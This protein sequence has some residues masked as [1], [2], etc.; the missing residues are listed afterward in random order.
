MKIYN[1]PSKTAEKKVASIV[2]RGLG[3][4]KKDVLA[5]TRILEDVRK[6]GDKALIKYANRFDSPG[7]TLESIQAT[8]QEINNAA[9]NVDQ[10]FARA[11]NRAAEQI[12][13]FHKQ[14]QY[15]SWDYSERP[16]TLLGQLI[17]P[18]DMAGVYVPGGMGGE[19][20]LVSSVLMGV[21]PAKVAGVEQILME[22]TV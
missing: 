22:Q 8:S 5:V 7:L 2:K 14:Q 3:F 4:K 13:S 9:K 1:Y 12:E 17:N 20:P 11:L 6:N 16:G 18:V 10:S 15:K 21:I 19:T